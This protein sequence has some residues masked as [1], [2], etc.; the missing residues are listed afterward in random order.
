VT[1]AATGEPVV[2]ATIAVEQGS[3]SSPIGP[4]YACT[5]SRAD[6]TYRID[7]FAADTWDFVKVS[8]PGWYQPLRTTTRVGNRL[9]ADGAV[10]V[11]LALARGGQVSGRVLGPDGPI[12]NASVALIGGSSGGVST[13]MKTKS[14]VDGSYLFEGV[15]HGPAALAVQA[16]EFVQEGWSGRWLEE[17][18]AGNVPAD[19]AIKVRGC[20]VV[21]HDV[22]LVR[23]L[24]VR[25]R[26]LA[27]D[28][29]AAAGANV[30]VSYPGVQD[31]EDPRGWLGNPL[32]TADTEGAFALTGVVP[33]SKIA[34][35]AWLSESGANQ[36]LTIARADV[37][38]V[39]LRLAPYGEPR[40]VHVHVIWPEGTAPPGALWFAGQWD[41]RIARS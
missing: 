10:T 27:A 30:R 25:G 8:K 3:G 22:H 7:H 13:P 4:A 5:T 34:V 24:T 12:P 35:S 26:V 38:D 40:T 17:F 18:R 14:G 23:G 39:S 20:E 36:E 9:P 29:S 28:G 41:E 19:A 16:A 2:G 33:D 6:G 15:P 31:I 32:G 1:D 37:R 11:D 21:T